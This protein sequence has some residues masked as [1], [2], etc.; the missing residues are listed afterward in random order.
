MKD[1]REKG[2]KIFSDVSLAAS[3][4][5]DSMDLLQELGVPPATTYHLLPGRSNSDDKGFKKFV[6][7]SVIEVQAK[8][9]ILSVFSASGTSSPVKF[10]FV[11]V[12]VMRVIQKAVEFEARAKVVDSVESNKQLGKSS[13]PAAP[14]VP[15]P[16]TPG[17]QQTLQESWG[18]AAV[19]SQFKDETVK[20]L[21]YLE[22]EIGKRARMSDKV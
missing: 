9:P 21:A 17:R 15:P 4:C 18:Q 8:Q 7:E 13:G 14:P 6:L 19:I 10:Y 22:E 5:F 12:N 16:P 2:T 3:E 11:P 1:S 20:K